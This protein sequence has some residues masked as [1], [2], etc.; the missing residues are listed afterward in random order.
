MASENPAEFAC[1]DL[2]AANRVSEAMM[3]AVAAPHADVY[4]DTFVDLDRG[5]F[6]RIGL[7]DRRYNRRLGSYV[8]ARL[9][10][11]LNDYGSDFTPGAYSEG[12]EGRLLIYE[13]PAAVFV[14][15]LPAVPG[16]RLVH[17]PVS[18]LKDTGPEGAAKRIELDSGA[19]RE[20][21]WQKEDDT[22]RLDVD[23]PCQAPVLVVFEVSGHQ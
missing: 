6:P 22:V 7:Y 11:V 10:G 20:V 21:A 9:Q 13:S 1:S 16:S 8:F 19:V 2:W 3:A 18:V 15:F 23:R 12:P 17:V 5:Y 14:L 4:L